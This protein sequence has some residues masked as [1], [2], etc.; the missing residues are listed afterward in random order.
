MPDFNS[1]KDRHESLGQ[2]KIGEEAIRKIINHPKLKSIPFI[3]ETPAL[4]SEETMGEEVK[5][6]LDWSE[7]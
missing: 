2:G 7:E 1:H 4:K 6:L 5:K 3:L